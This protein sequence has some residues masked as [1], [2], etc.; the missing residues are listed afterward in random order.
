MQT[1]SIGR[2]TLSFEEP[3]LARIRVVGDVT[4][5]EVDE[6]FT[7]LIASTEGRAPLLWLV[8]L[9][10]GGMLSA[11]SRRRA[12]YWRPRVRLGG[13]AVVHA[14]FEQRVVIKMISHVLQLSGLV[15]SQLN[16]FDDEAAAL[17]WLLSLRR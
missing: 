11:A 4:E 3:D 6:I 2:H 5:H 13:V 10:E 9:A 12:A 15:K 1:R 14:S 16:A 7:A 17:A 8:D